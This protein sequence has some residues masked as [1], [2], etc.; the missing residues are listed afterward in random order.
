M[1]KFASV[2]VCVQHCDS[3]CRPVLVLCVGPDHI[4]LYDSYYCRK[5]NNKDSKNDI[6]ITKSGSILSTNTCA[7]LDE[8]CNENI[9]L[10]CMPLMCFNNIKKLEPRP[11]AATIQG[12]MQIDVPKKCP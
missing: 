9:S 3:C 12:N 8:Q 11:C 2:C 6:R 5:K 4:C 7:V 1:Y 10:Y